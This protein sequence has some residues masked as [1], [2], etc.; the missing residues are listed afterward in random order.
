MEI[1]IGLLI[2]I[3]VLIGRASNT[4]AD[5]RAFSLMSDDELESVRAGAK[6]TLADRLSDDRLRRSADRVIHLTN[7]EK[8]KRLQGRRAQ[9]AVAG[10]AASVSGESTIDPMDGSYEPVFN[11][12]EE[13]DLD[14]LYES[15]PDF[16]SEDSARNDM[17]H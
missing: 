11:T 16:H 15:P 13:R 3:G 5:R 6:K 9:V 2:Y 12:Q 4:Y 7:R 14:K 17:N 10:M 8:G 1:L